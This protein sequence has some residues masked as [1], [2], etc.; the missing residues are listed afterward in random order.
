MDD[1]ERSFGGGPVRGGY[2]SGQFTSSTNAYM[3]MYRQID[4]RR[5]KN[6]MDQEE[7][8][9]HLKELHNLLERKAEEDRQM[10]ERERDMYK[11]PVHLADFMECGVRSWQFEC[12]RTTTVDDL[13]AM[14]VEVVIY[15]EFQLYV[16]V[17]QYIFDYNLLFF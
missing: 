6:A 2:Y 4:H 15:F 11:V 8:P 13:K 14:V 9:P 12:S 10:R 3:L 17:R 7:F 5:N 16:L 1:I